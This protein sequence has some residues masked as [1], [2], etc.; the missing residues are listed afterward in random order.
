M[1]TPKQI[2]EINKGDTENEK[3]LIKE[4]AEYVPDKYGNVTLEKKK[5]QIETEN[6]KFENEGKKSV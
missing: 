5:E 4:G 2:A 3:E 6:Q 1:L